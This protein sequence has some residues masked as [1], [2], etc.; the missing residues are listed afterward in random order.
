MT[1]NRGNVTVGGEVVLDWLEAI[2]VV[3]V[4]LPGLVCG[5]IV[6]DIFVLVVVVGGCGVCLC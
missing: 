2:F 5:G 4:L 1:R 6:D 3:V